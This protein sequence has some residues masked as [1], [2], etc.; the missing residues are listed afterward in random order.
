MAAQL[1]DVSTSLRA[2]LMVGERGERGPPRVVFRRTAG[3]L[4]HPQVA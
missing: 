3:P 2:R 1:L 4:A